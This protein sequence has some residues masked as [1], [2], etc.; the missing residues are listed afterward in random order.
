VLPPTLG[1][2]GDF[3]QVLG[4]ATAP[5]FFIWVQQL[6]RW[7]DPLPMGLLIPIGLLVLLFLIPY[8]IDRRSSGAGRWFN[9]EGRVAQWLVVLLMAAVAVLTLLSRMK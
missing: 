6:L 9:R 4:E 7:G 3:S 5:W 8:V 2:A 1:V